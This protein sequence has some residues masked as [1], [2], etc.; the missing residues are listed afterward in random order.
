[1]KSASSPINTSADSYKQHRVY[2]TR[3][4]IN[5][6]PGRLGKRHHFDG[7][8]PELR[9]AAGRNAFAID[10]V[11]VAAGH[12]PESVAVDQAM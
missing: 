6:L 3:P 12:F 1:M 7:N 2:A 8:G 10:R 5:L 9:A 11:A 4:A